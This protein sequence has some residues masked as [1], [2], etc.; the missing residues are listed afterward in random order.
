MARQKRPNDTGDSSA[1][2]TQADFDHLEIRDENQ[3]QGLGGSELSGAENSIIEDMGA[4]V[5]PNPP[6]LTSEPS[7]QSAT[8]KPATAITDAEA[9]YDQAA[10]DEMMDSA[11]EEDEDPDSIGDASAPSRN[12][13]SVEKPKAEKPKGLLQIEALREE[14]VPESEI[15]EWRKSLEEPLREEGVPDEEIAAYFGDAAYDEK[16]MAKLVEKAPEWF[17]PMALPDTKVDAK[18]ASGMGEAFAAGLQASSMGLAFRGELPDLKPKKDAHAGEIVAEAAGA[19]LGD[20]VPGL[21]GSLAGGVAGTA[22]TAN[23]AIGAGA[24]VFA[25]GAVPAAM[26]SQL[27]DY[28]KKGSINSSQDFVDRL[29]GMFAKAVKD[30]TINLLTAGAAKVG[31]GKAV[32][33]VG[34][35]I[36]GEIGKKIVSKAG[37][38]SAEALTMGAAGPAFEGRLPEKED[39]YHAAVAITGLNLGIHAAGKAAGSVKSKAIA[40]ATERVENN[41]SEKTMKIYQETG[42]TPPELTELAANDPVLHREILSG[43][44]EVPRSLT[45]LTENATK[46]TSPDYIEIEMGGGDGPE[47]T[48]KTVTIPQEL[49]ESLGGGTVDVDLRVPEADAAVA[50][51]ADP[52]P[53]GTI[54]EAKP[55]DAFRNLDPSQQKE[56]SLE[57][58]RKLVRGRIKDPSEKPGA[59]LRLS[60]I[61]RAILD[62]YDPVLRL[63]KALTGAKTKQEAIDALPASMNP[64]LLMRNLKGSVGRAITAVEHYTFDYDTFKKNGESL[65]EVLSKYQKDTNEAAFFEEYVTAKRAKELALRDKKT[66]FES[67]AAAADKV[68][69]SGKSKYGEDAKRL[70]QYQNRILKYAL[71]SGVISKES[72]DSMLANGENYVPMKRFFEGDPSD[73]MGIGTGVTVKNVIK[74]LKGSEREVLSPIQMIVRNTHDV[75]TMAE[76]NRAMRSLQDLLGDN[77]ELMRLKETDKGKVVEVGGEEAVQFRKLEDNEIAVYEDGKRMV[78]EV[79]DDI[80]KAVRGLDEKAVDL[81]LKPLAATASALRAG[82]TLTPDFLLKNVFRDQL[83]AF[84]MSNN[85]Y[86]PVI[87]YLSGLASMVKK[88]EAFVKWMQGGGMN[89]TMQSLDRDYIRGNIFALAK[90]TGF[91][92]TAKNVISHPLQLLRELSEFGELPTRLG[93]YKRATKGSTDINTVLKGAYDARN[94]TID[95]QKRGANVAALNAITPFFNARNQGLEQVYTALKEHT[96][97]TL[98]RGSALSAAA[99]WLWSVN[100]EDPRYAELKAWEKNLFFIFMTD[101]WVPAREKEIGQPNTRQRKDGTWEINQGRIFKV[102]KPQEFGLIFASMPEAALDAWKRDDPAAAKEFASAIASSFIPDAPHLPKL[103]AEI[104]ANHSYFRNQSIVPYYTSQLLPEDQYTEFTSE[105]AKFLSS[106]LAKAGISGSF[107]APAMM[108]YAAKATFGGMADYGL[109]ASDAALSF[110]L[111]KMGYPPIPMRTKDWDEQVFVKSF[112]VRQPESTRSVDDFYGI[113]AALDRY[114]L[115]YSAAKKN[116]NKARMAELERDPEWQIADHFKS[117]LRGARKDMSEIRASVT[118]VHS[119]PEKEMPKNDKLRLIDQFLHQ[120]AK[121]ARSINA[122]YRKVRKTV[123]SGKTIDDAYLPEEGEEVESE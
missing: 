102:P 79:P 61:Q 69:E 29:T 25:F 40:A 70:V 110:T 27:V 46:K 28:Y 97:R 50:M 86:I 58:A 4:G 19:M 120:R 76:R 55:S 93:E 123:D 96:G 37:S 115:S 42:I 5:T 85:S 11:D 82:A 38:L 122:E 90:E 21:A 63:Q 60:N 65:N 106:K 81:M 84:V 18:E 68:I 121:I 103:V 66:G 118:Q 99:V 34:E 92:K 16:P 41:V 35:K 9:G 83:H 6:Q 31:G 23:P 30:G 51:D 116:G 43:S 49:P 114:N 77:E 48:R 39:F 104:S 62:E 53:A 22:A 47:L 108:D 98:L 57:E 54:A 8:P 7:T 74:K 78:F 13:A 112:T 36:A 14:G 95:F 44:Q 105:T 59:D 20:L 24:G 15:L 73:G 33:K 17:P 100:H 32:E 75:M 2:L 107:T 91:M 94:I 87:S 101:N 88:D 12:P 113:A 1:G 119:I 45:E 52:N 56:I 109:A 3:A 72:Y 89:A 80:A 71:D 10:Y 26:R 67:I 111:E 117:E 64:Y